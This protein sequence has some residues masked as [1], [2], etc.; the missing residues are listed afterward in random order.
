MND[1]APPGYKI[2]SVPGTVSEFRMFKKQDGTIE[3]H[4]RYVNKGVGYTGKW[5][6]VSVVEEQNHGDRSTA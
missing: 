2:Y 5:I 1:M 6:V 3:Q 4:V